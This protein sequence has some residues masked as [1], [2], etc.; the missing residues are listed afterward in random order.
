MK[1]LKE[2]LMSFKNKLV[3]KLIADQVVDYGVSGSDILIA[4]FQNSKRV[5]KD[6]RTKA[7][8]QEFYM[9]LGKQEG[10]LEAID[11]VIQ[12]SAPIILASKKLATDFAEVCEE[13]HEEYMEKHFSPISEGITRRR[14]DREEKLDALIN[15]E[16]E[17]Q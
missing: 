15:P 11:T 4:L 10:L 9:E 8:F 17:V 7:A 6:K 12:N 16:E 2:L 13:Y 3:C 5:W 14:A 1:A